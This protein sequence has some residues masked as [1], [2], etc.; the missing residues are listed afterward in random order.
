MHGSCVPTDCMIDSCQLLVYTL[1]VIGAFPVFS[2][3]LNLMLHFGMEKEEST[4]LLVMFHAPHLNACSELE[5][6]LLRS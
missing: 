2:A 5:C 4:C 1:V 6:A 3:H